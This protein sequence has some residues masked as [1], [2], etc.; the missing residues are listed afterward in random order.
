M[1]PEFRAILEVLAKAVPRPKYKE[2]KDP[3]Q[4]FPD[5]V[6]K[7][8]YAKEALEALSVLYDKDQT[9]VFKL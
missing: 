2:G 6:H 1:Q 3:A 7:S 8:G 9:K 4:Q 5:M